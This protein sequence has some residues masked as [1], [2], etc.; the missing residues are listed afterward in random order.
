[1]DGGLSFMDSSPA[2]LALVL[3]LFM[4]LMLLLM[5]LLLLLSGRKLLELLCGAW[6]LPAG[7]V[8]LGEDAAVGLFSN[9]D[10]GEVAS[11]T[12]VLEELRLLVPRL[13][14]F[15]PILLP[16]TPRLLLLR[17]ELSPILT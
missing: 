7:E 2:S 5:L 1:M 4:L 10:L 6:V 13:C 16:P 14:I 11:P 3:V 12:L 8:C 9:S 15:P 17:A